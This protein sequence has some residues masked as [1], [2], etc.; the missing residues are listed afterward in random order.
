M[1]ERLSVLDLEPELAELLPRD[2]LDEARAAALAVVNDLPAGPWAPERAPAGGFLIVHGCLSHEVAVLGKT[3][4]IDFLAH[5]D[6]FHT[7][8]A[9]VMTSVAAESSWH[10]LEPTRVALLDERFLTAVQPWPHLT[11]ALLLRQERRSAWLAHILAI[12]HLPRVPSRVL[13]LLWL[14]ADRWG[15]RTGS[16]VQ[17]PIPL[18]HLEIARLIGARRPTVTTILNQLIASGRVAHTRQGHWILYGEPPTMPPA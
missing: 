17:V 14:F 15:H 1:G 12:S 5:G 11:A 4:A 6:V 16:F 7:A 2:R 13:V 9:P 10:V 18:T 3:T 8:V